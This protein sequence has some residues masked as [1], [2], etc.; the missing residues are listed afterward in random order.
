MKK[1]FSYIFIVA[2][3]TVFIPSHIVFADNHSDASPATAATAAVA[4]GGALGIPGAGVARSLVSGEALGGYVIAVMAAVTESVLKILALLVWISGTTLNFVL[5]Y[6]IIDMSAHINGGLDSFGTQSEPMVGINVAWKVIKDLMNIAFI[7][8]LVYEGIKMIIGVSKDGA[9]TLIVGII[10]ASLLIN[11][12]LFFTKIIID[13]SNIVTIGFYNSV[14]DDSMTLTPRSQQGAS[15]TG[16]ANNAGTATPATNTPDRGVVT[17]LSVPFMKALGVGKFWS[18]EAFQSLHSSPN[19]DKNTIIYNIGGSILFI[20]TAF[21]FFAVSVMFVIR[22]ITLIFLLMLSPIG[23]MGL[24]IPQ[25]RTYATQWWG[26]LNSQL[27]FAPLYMLMTWIALTLLSSPGF[28]TLTGD[29]DW[30]RLVVGENGQGDVNSIGLIFNFVLVIGLM[31]M[32]LYIAQNVSK[33]GSTLIGDATKWAT[34]AAGGFIAGGAAG[35]LRTSVGRAALGKSS[36]EDLQSRASAGDLRAKSRLALA[37]SSF[38]V[39]K[40]KIVE[41]TASATG[42]GF[43]KGTE[44]VPFLGNP[45][46][47]VG[48]FNATK[49]QNKK[50]NDER[51]EQITKPF[52]NKRDWTGLADAMRNKPLATLRSTWESQQQSTY[53][54][55]SGR[56]RVSLEKAL[57]SSMGVAAAPF[58]DTMRSKLPIDDQIK[59]YTDN[60]EWSSMSKF[61]MAKNAQ[62]QDYV[63]EKM[64]A[65]DRVNLDEELATITATGTVLSGR[66]TIKRMRRAL[67]LEEQEKTTESEK[68]V[69]KEFKTNEKIELI[70]KLVESTIAR[71]PGPINPLTGVPY[72]Y[73]ELVGVG[74]LSPSETRRLGPESRKDPEIIKLLSPRHLKDLM[75]GGLEDDEV[76]AITSTI[77]PPG[78]PVGVAPATFRDP[79]HKLQYEY[80]I[81]PAV[82]DLWGV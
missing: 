67:S 42:V 65:R 53:K 22:Y 32:T 55:L 28:I 72:T 26:A 77:I 66:D 54:K 70:K 5:D 31:I 71:T 30:A 48:G 61:L 40:S 51:M 1:I 58:I 79:N 21:S 9:K 15:A 56:D 63:Y 39:R 37:T 50:E 43:G 46:A 75:D 25:M 38:D 78:T 73:V 57:T 36:M 62:E 74:K 47:G 35:I 41:R 7:F 68:K 60:K 4:L 64:S 81:K 76:L 6:T 18:L 10:S 82:K 24:A 14:I 33:K 16:P 19:A 2:L 52:I 12:S 20:V 17:G 59:T 23:Y 44:G 69:K 8:L 45:N 49:T 29:G 34:G 13:A 80:I 3:V 11:F 27:L